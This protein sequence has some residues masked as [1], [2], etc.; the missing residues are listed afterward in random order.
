MHMQPVFAGCECVGNGVAEALFRDG[1]CLPSGSNLSEIAW[2]R[3][4]APCNVSGHFP[5]PQAW[6][7]AHGRERLVYNGGRIG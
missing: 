4:C 7:I 5:V 1:L 2:R 6:P 3:W